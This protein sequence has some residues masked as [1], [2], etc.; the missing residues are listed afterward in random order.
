M[1]PDDDLASSGV[2]SDWVDADRLLDLL[3]HAVI[4][5]D[6]GGHIVRWNAAAERLYGWTAEEILGRNI[7]EVTVPEAGQ[8]HGDD[9]M[10]SLREGRSWSGGFTVV[11]KDGSTFSALVTD[12]GVRTHDGRL[13]G[14]VGVSTDLG[15]AL[16]PLLA[17]SSDAVLVMSRSGTV[18]YASPAFTR[19]FGWAEE[20][21]LGMRLWDLVH[22]DDRPVVMQAPA[23]EQRDEPPALECRLR[24]PDDSWR[25]VEMVV[26]DLLD[27]PAVRGRICNIRD[28]TER[29]S[30]Q[31]RLTELNEQLESALQSRVVIEQAKGMLAERRGTSVEEAFQVLRKHARDHNA[32]LHEVATAVVTLGLSP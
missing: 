29:R 31:E 19:L 22:P 10:Q 32:S 13:V 26:S 24:C 25:W 30:A 23:L 15:H 1:A 2:T 12:V 16:R 8:E 6:L 14:I 11:R 17:R 27:D 18:S 4:A 3:G 9:I 7:R 28:V 5:T 20:S 21:V